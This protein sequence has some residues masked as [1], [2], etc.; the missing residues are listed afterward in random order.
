[1]QETETYT[2]IIR[3][4]LTV[5]H[6]AL[7]RGWVQGIELSELAQR[8]LAALG[9]DDGSVD[10][11]LAKTTLTRVLNEIADYA[12]RAG[13]TDAVVL[14]RQASRI[15]VKPGAPTLEDFADTLDD[16]DFY[17]E[18]EL[19]EKYEET[20]AE[21]SRSQARRARLIQRQLNLLT[22]LNHFLAAPMTLGDRVGDWFSDAITDKLNSAGI[23]SIETLMVHIVRDPD[24]WF[25]D[26][27]GMG[28]GKAKRIY[29]FL[30]TQRGPLDE[31]LA[32]AGISIPS[33][34][35]PLSV[36]SGFRDLI[37][38]A[39]QSS[40]LP[41]PALPGIPVAAAT[42]LPS[43][44]A[45]S[46][47]SAQL[48]GSQGRLRA[49][50]EQSAIRAGNDLEALNTW[51]DQKASTA[52]QALY[53][54][55]IE[56]LMMWS[57]RIKG[58]PLSS[59]ATED[60]HEYRAFLANVPADWVCK[61]GT[62]QNDPSWTPFAGS[63]SDSS[64]KKSLVIIN[65]FFT[66]LVEKN[67]C[68]ANPFAGVKVKIALPALADLST[69]ADDEESLE[70]SRSR[71]DSL[72]T[73][74]LPYL[75]IQA[76]ETELEEGLQDEFIARARFVFR[77]CL[78]T[79]LRI[80]EAAAARRDHLVR[81]EPKANDPGGWELRVVG[82]RSKHRAVPFPDS[83]VDDLMAYLASRN[84]YG[85]IATIPP[86]TFL[87][88]RLPSVLKDA[89]PGDGVRPLA[90]HR[91]LE[92]LFERAANRVGANDAAAADQLRKA[93]AHWLRHTCATDAVAAEVP[94]DV[95]ASTLGHSSLSTTSRYV[96]TESRRRLR[97]MQK[98]WENGAENSGP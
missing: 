33:R 42:S 57:T 5:S 69:R 8:Y 71:M 10:L 45:R 18:R 37:E 26:I 61:K 35:M 3:P 11:R 87:I 86:G 51:L 40:A 7:V 92:L 77:L 70:F 41:S 94:L 4:L 30:V 74:T 80:S 14:H 62:Y 28:F 20:Y 95:V 64:A 53:R 98:Y 6:F 83:L 79:G 88:G 49:D 29:N 43:P 84:I 19:I 32:K 81:I 16:P 66:W 97:E 12:K 93:S 13:K 72:V 54:R 15:R 68:V 47:S 75:A 46:A 73:R 21:A 44:S 59:L 22:D 56:R 78:L 34:S 85:S 27:K 39:A 36:T 17:T 65:G 63:L 55:E 60:A 82:K 90:I 76:V 1:M 50:P 24:G 48:N 38:T 31:D 58:I 89:A 96:H 23:A 91:A 9:D 25:D 52:T 2:S 67:Y